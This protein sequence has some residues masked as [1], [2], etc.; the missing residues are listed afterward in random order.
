MAKNKEV[1]LV[2][3]TKTVIG[4]LESL[5]SI[6]HAI[7]LVCKAPSAPLQVPKD[8]VNKYKGAMHDAS[9]LQM[10]TTWARVAD[11]SI[12]NFHKSNSAKSVLADLGTYSPGIAVARLAMGIKVGDEYI[13]RREALR[14]ATTKMINTDVGNMN[15]IIHGRTIDLPCVSGVNVQYLKPLFAARDKTAVRDKS[16]MREML[17]QLFGII[18]KKDAGLIPDTFIDACSIFTSELF[19]NT[20]E[21]ATTDHRGEPYDGHVEGMIVSWDEMEA[22]FFKKD[23]EG[24]QR[25]REFWEREKVTIRGSEGIRCLQLS[26]F[27]TGPGFASRHSGLDVDDLSIA[28]E[29]T[30][31]SKCLLKNITTK[32][33][34]GSGGGLALV[35]EELRTIGGLI[36]IRS[37]RLSI[38][39][40]FRKDQLDS[41]HSFDDWSDK[42]LGKVSGALVSI[43]VPLRRQ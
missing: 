21:H 36:R 37:G 8:A 16:G 5:E 13:S 29:R 19:L 12:L 1:V 18:N 38:F 22:R 15:N 31:L 33:Q 9:R 26:F 4:D 27:D 7:S 32:N 23:F 3:L 43:L 34:T 25:L 35:L 2:E 14:S 17:G 20:Q 24:H 6:E 42:G 41:I 28:E 30:Y 11:S 40:C 10:L 39:N